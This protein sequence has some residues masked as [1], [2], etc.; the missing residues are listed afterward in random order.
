MAGFFKFERAP[1]DIS[2]ILVIQAQDGM[3]REVGAIASFINML[4]SSRKNTRMWFAASGNAAQF[5]PKSFYAVG[6]GVAADKGQIRLLA[7]P[8]T[9]I[10]WPGGILIE[11]RRS[12][13]IIGGLDGWVE[14]V[15]LGR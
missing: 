9:W 10:K 3:Q 13:V 12:R 2:L 14:L 11:M 1:G 4:K 7:C 5:V 6:G 15:I 8:V